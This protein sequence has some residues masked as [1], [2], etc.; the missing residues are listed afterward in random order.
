MAPALSSPHT[1]DLE[2]AVA[3]SENPL[4]LSVVE[5]VY[6]TAYQKRGLDVC[7][8]TPVPR[9]LQ[10]ESVDYQITL[11]DSYTGV[12]FQS[13]CELKTEKHCYGRIS[14]ET[15]SAYEAGKPGWGFKETGINEQRLMTIWFDGLVFMPYLDAYK[16]WLADNRERLEAQVGIHPDYKAFSCS[17]KAFGKGY[18]SCGFTVPITELR[19]A[20]GT[21]CWH[22]LEG[23][24]LR[25]AQDGIDAIGKANKGSTK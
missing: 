5:S 16:C 19:D 3:A 13:Y 1:Y 9:A 2:A 21:N 7:E 11:A 15:W 12:G 14:V 17:N 25:L 23:V 24:P 10:A 6:R 22:R 18:T 8:V 4:W 20:F